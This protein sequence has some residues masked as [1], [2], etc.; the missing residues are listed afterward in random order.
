VYISADC[1]ILV[2]TQDN[3]FYILFK[4]YFPCAGRVIIYARRYF[5]PVRSGLVQLQLLVYFVQYTRLESRLLTGPCH[6][7]FTKHRAA[8][9]QGTPFPPLLLLCPFTFSSFA[10]YY[11]F[12]FSFSHSLYLFSS[13]VHPIPFY[14]QNRPTPFPG[15][16]S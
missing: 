16:R 10:F 14:L 7:K 12:P 6:Q 3:I 4:C 2:K 1:D 13:I 9:G 11:F 8:W 5:P 15:R